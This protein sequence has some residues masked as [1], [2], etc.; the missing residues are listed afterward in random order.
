M[1][2]CSP[3]CG[4]AEQ[5]RVFLELLRSSFRT[6]KNKVTQQVLSKRNVSITKKLDRTLYI[7]KKSKHLLRSK[8]VNIVHDFTQ[9]QP[10]NCHVPNATG[11]ENLQ[12]VGRTDV[13]DRDRNA[14]E[15]RRLLQSEKKGVREDFLENSS[16]KKS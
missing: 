5:K 3:N 9:I 15:H 4:I 10:G 13:E 8:K 12:S 1:G 16:K 7:K 2:S 14:E 11:L 6:K